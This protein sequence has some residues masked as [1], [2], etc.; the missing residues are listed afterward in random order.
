M[1]LLLPLVLGL[2]LLLPSGCAYKGHYSFAGSRKLADSDA[3]LITKVVFLPFTSLGEGLVSP[4]TWYMDASGY[5]ET[6][7]NV[8]YSYIGTKT[9]LAS[10]MNDAYKFVGSVFIIP[11]DTLWFPIG[12]L[13]DLFS[14]W[15]RSGPG[16]DVQ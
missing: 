4:F 1:K 15:G 12:G 6:K 7:E 9:L 5:S 16:G 11:V 10:D 13:I 2:V 8:Y 3:P 14:I